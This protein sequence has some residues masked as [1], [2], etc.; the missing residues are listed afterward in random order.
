MALLIGGGTSVIVN[1]GKKLWVSVHPLLHNW[2]IT[3]N[4]G[5]VQ[6]VEKPE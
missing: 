6:E 5:S 4:V 2:L 3:D 1:G